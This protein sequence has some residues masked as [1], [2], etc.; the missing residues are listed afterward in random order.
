VE[1]SVR[2]LYAIEA[3]GPID[4]VK[5]GVATDV[6]D[7]LR[8][9]STGSPVPLAVSRIWHGK[10]HLES[11]LHKHLHEHRLH[12]EWF[13][14]S[15][16]DV[17]RVLSADD[18]EDH[19]NLHW[20][21]RRKPERERRSATVKQNLS[22]RDEMLSALQGCELD[23]W[24]EDV[25]P[26]DKLHSA[27]RALNNPRYTSRFFTALGALTYLFVHPEGLYQHAGKVKAYNARSVDT[28]MRSL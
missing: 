15:A 27:A 4:A 12:G 5:F 1:V 26:S 6:T 7:R 16:G 25:Y 21:E 22:W 20:S 28:I 10:G 9:L 23:G 11:R 8:S 13:S 14:L 2:D 3:V 19:L 17:Q 24:G 18:V